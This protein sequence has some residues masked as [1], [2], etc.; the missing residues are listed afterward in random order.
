MPDP[1]DYQR[2]TKREIL[3]TLPAKYLRMISPTTEKG[4]RSTE[5]HDRR[6]QR[7]DVKIENL[8][9]NQVHNETRVSER[10]DGSELGQKPAQHV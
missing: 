10:T 8:K 1:P 9:T 5:K 3:M 7:S 2:L 4:S 6:D